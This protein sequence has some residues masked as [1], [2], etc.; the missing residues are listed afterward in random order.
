M[1]SLDVEDQ[2]T[3]S[4]VVYPLLVFLDPLSWS[5]PICKIYKISK[6]NTILQLYE[7]YRVGGSK[8]N[9]NYHY[10]RCLLLKIFELVAQVLLSN[11]VL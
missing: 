1:M 10:T 8:K 3:R 5:R 6:S 4:E 11:Q 9:L 2:E 7:G